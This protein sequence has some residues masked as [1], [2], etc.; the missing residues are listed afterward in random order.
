MDLEHWTAQM[1]RNAR[2]IRSMAED[3][4][5]EQAR[6][7]PAPDRWSILEVINHLYDEEQEDFGVHLDHIL[8]QPDRPWPR[9]DPQ[10]W[11]T[12]RHYNQRDLASS[13]EDFIQ[14]RERSIA[15]LRALPPPDWQA[16]ATAPFG[17]IAAG[18]VFASWVA[19]DLMHIRQ[20]VRLHFGYTVR[21]LQP[22]KVAYA[23]DWTL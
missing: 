22:Y 21:A 1:A 20:L 6:W 4:S 5:E 17:Q 8:T 13:V 12:E 14:A 7:K 9:I 2:I 11:V 3:V 10:G 19:H 15:W 16:A 23:G 18:D